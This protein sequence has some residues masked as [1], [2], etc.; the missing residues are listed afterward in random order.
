MCF[1]GERK[2]EQL[3]KTE[4]SLNTV[5][6]MIN[7]VW[8]FGSIYS[9][10][11]FKYGEMGK[12][13]QFTLKI[14]KNLQAVVEGVKWSPVAFLW[15]F[16]HVIFIWNFGR[17]PNRTSLRECL[18]DS[19]PTA[20]LRSGRGGTHANPTQPQVPIE[21][22]LFCTGLWNINTRWK[23]PHAALSSIPLVPL[24]GLMI[25]AP[26]LQLLL[27][28]PLHTGGRWAAN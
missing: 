7:T 25:P 20:Q 18:L 16:P 21:N 17:A 24:Q 23:E 12:K 11:Y 10:I 13:Y 6:T 22:K 9:L 19:I 14:M 15:M 27:P 4:W 5:I 1:R 2:K 28:P 3:L 26:P 8:W